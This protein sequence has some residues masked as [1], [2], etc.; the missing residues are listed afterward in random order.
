MTSKSRGDFLKENKHGQKCNATGFI[1]FN[2]TRL[3]SS[4]ICFT[5]DGN[6]FSTRKPGN[7]SDCLLST[8][9]ITLFFK[10][11]NVKTSKIF[12]RANVTRNVRGFKEILLWTGFG[13]G[14]NQLEEKRF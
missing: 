3:V 5:T 2:Q 4:L 8:V 1:V 14:C 11:P 7:G 10:S 12:P 13:S 9:F 6:V